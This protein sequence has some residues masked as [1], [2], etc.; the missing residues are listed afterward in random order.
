MKAKD[1]KERKEDKQK[2]VGIKKIVGLG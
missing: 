2:T 1:Q